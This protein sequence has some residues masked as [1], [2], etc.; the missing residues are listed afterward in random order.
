[1]QTRCFRPYFEM[2][3][4]GEEGEHGNWFWLVE[5]VVAEEEGPANTPETVGQRQDKED[6]AE[7]GGAVGRWVWIPAEDG[8]RQG[9]PLS[10]ML[11]ALVGVRCVLAAQMLEWHRGTTALATGPPGA[12]GF[13]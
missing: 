5:D 9:A 8:M 13:A 12:K 3:Y 4:M 10:C 11:V 7:R 2:A 6:R 1:M